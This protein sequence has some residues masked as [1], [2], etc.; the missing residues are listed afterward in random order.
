MHHLRTEQLQLRDHQLTL[1]QSLLQEEGLRLSYTSLQ[2]TD[3]SLLGL[4][5]TILLPSESH[6]CKMQLIVSVQVSALNC[7]SA[8]TVQ[9]LR[10]LKK[11]IELLLQVA[12][13]SSRL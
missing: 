7:V 5:A 11:A 10:A 9:A 13:V 1:L 2:V 6:E 4:H 8:L 3:S 12:R